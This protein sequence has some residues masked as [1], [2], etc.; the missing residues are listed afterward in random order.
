MQVCFKRYVH[1]RGISVIVLLRS[2]V[3]VV[4]LSLDTASDPKFTS[5]IDPDTGVVSVF[6]PDTKADGGGEK[7]PVC[8]KLWDMAAA[9]VACREHGNP[10]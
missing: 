1:Q 7:L 6:I 3:S 10:L 8:K 4:S 5:S 9:N 2:N